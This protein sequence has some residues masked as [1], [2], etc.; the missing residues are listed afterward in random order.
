MLLAT[1][2]SSVATSSGGSTSPKP[3]P[4]AAAVGYN[5]RT[6]GPAITLDSN[7]F[8]FNFLNNS[9]PTAQATQNSD[10]SVLL[11]GAASNTYSAGICPARFSSDPILAPKQFRGPA[12]GGGAYF[13]AA[14]SFPPGSGQNGSPGFPT[15]WTLPIEHL[16][17]AGADAWT[18]QAGYSRW[19]EID[20]LEYLNGTAVQ[21][22]ITI[23]DWTFDGTNTVDHSHSVLVSIGTANFANVNKLGI[24]WV[25]ATASTN[26]YFAVYFN[27]VQIVANY[28]WTQFNPGTAPPPSDG[29]T[30]GNFMDVCHHVPILGTSSTSYPMT[31]QTMSIWQA[32]A[33]NNLSY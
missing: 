1:T 18:G 30:L 12:F 5:T 28:T 23:H 27:D 22:R 25:P 16:A 20:G 3:P 33:A 14:F 11:S 7:W 26:G 8:R 32:S 31:L 15:F 13:E 2:S 17:Q 10:G 9:P 21:F 6:F 29:T 4:A 19:I 24:L